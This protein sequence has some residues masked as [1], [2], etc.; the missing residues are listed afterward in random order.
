MWI[1]RCAL[2]V[3]CLVSPAIAQDA[4]A[5]PTSRLQAKLDAL[6][7]TC[8]FPAASLGVV[9]KDG[10]ALALAT[11]ECV[12][13]V[14]LKPDDLMLQGSTGKTYFGALAM[15]LVEE[16][17]LE[18]DAPI[19]KYL[20]GEP[21]FPRL[22]HRDDV[23]V[24][25]LMNH[26]SGLERY[27]LDPRFLADLKREP[28]RTWTV[29][30]RLEYVLD[31]EPPFLPGKGWV[32]SDTN[33]IVLGAVLE[34][35]C[36]RPLYDEI[37]ARFLAPLALGHTQPSDGRRIPGLAQGH[38]AKGDPFIAGDVLLGDDGQLVLDPQFEW[39]GGGFASSAPDLARWCAALYGGKVLRPESLEL[40]QETVECELWKGARYGLGCIVTETSLGKA[41]GHAGFFPGYVSEMRFYAEHGTAL[42]I[43]IDTSDFAKIRKPLGAML[44]ELA[45]IAVEE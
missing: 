21:W 45:A 3:A 44:D 9:L 16:K 19:G 11:G 22:K 33:F 5:D 38:V 28:M 7:E 37:R 1:G 17:L 30:Q 40:M 13:G 10:R 20:A 6:R 43:Q 2:S 31:R 26:T 34:K 15:R 14:A 29:A 23:T 18:I 25:M 24:R 4:P 12:P 41:L 8:G 32:Y 39:A 42:A 36:E 35:L 27:E